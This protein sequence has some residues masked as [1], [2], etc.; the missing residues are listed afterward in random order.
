MESPIALVKGNET[1]LT[2]LLHENH[3]WRWD[4]IMIYWHFCT[5]SWRW[6]RRRKLKPAKA[7]WLS[8]STQNL[9][10][11]RLRL[12]TGGLGGDDSWLVGSIEGILLLQSHL[13]SLMARKMT[14]IA[15]SATA[16]EFIGTESF[17]GQVSTD[18]SQSS[19]KDKV[20]AAAAEAIKP[21]RLG[22]WWQ[23]SFWRKNDHPNRERGDSI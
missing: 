4:A 12:V 2:R 1:Y 23:S 6:S 13:G 9:R 19:E 21:P 14:A 3:K 16:I 17:W 10:S 11:S 18:S 8:I 20:A 22:H 5:S 15:R 7:G